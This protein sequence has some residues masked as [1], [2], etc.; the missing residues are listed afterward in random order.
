MPSGTGSSTTFGSGI[1]ETNMIRLRTG[2]LSVGR[3]GGWSPAPLRPLADLDTVI[4]AHST[5]LRAR[6]RVLGLFMALHE[7]LPW[8]SGA[9]PPRSQRTTELPRYLAM[10]KDNFTLEA[11][12]DFTIS[13]TT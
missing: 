8:L 9:R 13:E 4:S 10:M 6:L 3:K 2:T 12:G 1:R 11:H 7:I 5:L